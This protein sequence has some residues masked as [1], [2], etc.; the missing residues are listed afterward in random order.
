MLHEENDSF[1]N[2]DDDGNDGD[3]SFEGPDLTTEEEERLGDSFDGSGMQDIRP[4]SPVPQFLA[5]E[6]SPQQ[7]Q[8][9]PSRTKAIGSQ[10]ALPEKFGQLIPQFTPN[11]QLRAG[12]IFRAILSNPSIDF[13]ELTHSVFVNEKKLGR[14]N[15]VDAVTQLLTAHNLPSQQRKRQKISPEMHM[16]IQALSKSNL[17]GQTISNKQMRALFEKYRASPVDGETSSQSSDDDDDV[18][19][20]RYSD[21]ELTEAEERATRAWITSPSLLKLRSGKT[22]P[23]KRPL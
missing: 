9:G 7:Q 22:Y 21:L 11:K 23:R 6:Q 16:L 5:Q 3:V 20:G 14:L 10:G 19:F 15:L 12:Q 1:D 8:P 13:D 2:G 4:A 18:N 17:A